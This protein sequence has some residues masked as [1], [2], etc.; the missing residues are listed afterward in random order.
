MFDLLPVARQNYYHPDM[1]GSWSIKAVLPT[2]AP[3]LAYDGLEVGNGGMAQE[4]FAEILHPDTPQARREQLR[5]AL[6]IYCER[7][8]PW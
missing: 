8:P 5:N 2:I 1:R 7:L 3:E 6:L 4:A